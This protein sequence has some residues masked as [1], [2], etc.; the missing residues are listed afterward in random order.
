VTEISR[1]DLL[2]RLHTRSLTLVDV[3]PA[4]SYAAG[5]ISGALSLPLEDVASRARELLPD[6]SA[7]IV[8]YC[9]KFT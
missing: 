6:R 9:S 8:V 3:L 4:E 5:H 7:E 1:E 2:H